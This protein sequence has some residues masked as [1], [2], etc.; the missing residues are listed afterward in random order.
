MLTLEPAGPHELPGLVIGVLP[1]AESQPF[2]D[3]VVANRLRSQTL[4]ESLNL[5]DHGWHPGALPNNAELRK[6]DAFDRP[7]KLGL[8]FVHKSG[9]LAPMD[10]DIRDLI[11]LLTNRV[12]TLMEGHSVVA[13]TCGARSEDDAA[14]VF[15]D[16][17]AAVA[18]M[19][20]LIVAAKAILA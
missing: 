4:D 3:A 5:L 14:A 11:S 19:G 16:L 20:A 7:E 18:Q 6:A 13:L 8:D 1:N 15:E 9:R 10:A 17:E 2:G 12:G